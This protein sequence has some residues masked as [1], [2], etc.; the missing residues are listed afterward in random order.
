[1]VAKAEGVFKMISSI[2]FVK[3]Q[4]LTPREGLSPRQ[5]KQLPLNKIR[6]RA[7]LVP[8]IENPP[9]AKLGAYVPSVL[10][11]T[12]VVIQQNGKKM[13]LKVLLN[14]PKPPSL[15]VF[16]PSRLGPSTLNNPELVPV[17]ERVQ[18]PRRLAI[19]NLY[20][21]ARSGHEALVVSMPEELW[22]R[23]PQDKRRALLKFVRE[24]ATEFTTLKVRPDKV[25]GYQSPYMPPQPVAAIAADLGLANRQKLGT[26][27][28]FRVVAPKTYQGVIDK[29]LKLIAEIKDSQAKLMVQPQRIPYNPDEQSTVRRFDLAL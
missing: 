17:F 19:A 20:N 2:Q 26:T 6:A 12:G 27:R 4:T 9:K 23:I 10:G 8:D 7:G 29:L 11:V 3:I 24:Q 18:L 28:Y 21:Q 13:P 1:M 22:R 25:L 14:R 15:V 16:E 5:A